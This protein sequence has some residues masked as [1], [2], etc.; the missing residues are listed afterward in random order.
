[1]ISV[2]IDSTTGNEIVSTT[3]IKSYARIETSSDDTIIGIMRTA[4]R[5]SCEDYMN[6]D[7]VAKTRTYFRSDI[8]N[9]SG[10]YDGLYDERYKILLPFAPIASVTS[11]KTE[12]SDGTFA[13]LSY[14]KYGADD[15]YIVLKG[16][17]ASN[18][19]IEYV[20][21]GMEDNSLKLAIMQLA[22]T[23]YDNRTEF[24]STSVNKIPTSIKKILDPYKYISDL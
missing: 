17:E 19:K 18:V 9:G 10:H 3:D 4:A 11:V 12:K 13:D 16:Y 2:Q 24:V 6:R 20:T 7:I 22:S 23:F 14:E 1:M 15:K 5:T 21:T 8:P